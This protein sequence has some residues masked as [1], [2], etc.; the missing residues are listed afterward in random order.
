MFESRLL[1][2]CVYCYER[3][4]WLGSNL[5]SL[6]LLYFRC[7]WGYEFFRAGLYQLN[8]LQPS[9]ELFSQVGPPLANLYAPL[10]SRFEM[11][12]GIFL[13]IGL[14]SRLSAIPLILIASIALQAIENPTNIHTHFLLDPTFFSTLS[15]YPF[16]FSALLIFIFG[17]GRLS[18]DA[19]LKRH[20]DELRS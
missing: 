2:F 4:I 16:L 14:G 19:I 9:V 13:I 3:I 7:T 11:G 18:I 6:F 10:V 1:A 5:Q 15:P 12:C 8:A 17:P 20:I